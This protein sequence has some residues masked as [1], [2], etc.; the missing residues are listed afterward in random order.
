MGDTVKRPHPHAA[1]R[2]VEQGL[3]PRAHFRRGLVGESDREHALG[4]HALHLDQPGDA[5]HQHAGLA[6]PGA[7]DDKQVAQGSGDGFALPLVQGPDNARYVQP[8]L[9]GNRFRQVSRLVH[10]RALQH[11]HVIGE[12]LQRDRVD[13]GRHGIVHVRDF[14]DGEALSLAETRFRIGEDVELATRARTS[15]RFD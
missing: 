5:M 14:D 2:H 3:R 11:R 4:A 8:L 1:P 13:D 10:V 6:A 12:Q 15:C 9:D 7:G